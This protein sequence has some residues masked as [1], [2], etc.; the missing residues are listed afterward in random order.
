MPEQF[1]DATT[2]KV[3]DDDFAA[4]ITTLQTRVAADDVRR[5]SLPQAPE[6]YKGE[7]PADFKMPD[8]IT[9]KL[10]ETNPAYVEAR[11]MAH[12]MGLDQAQF[13]K[14]LSA[15]AG[16]L[17]QEQVT[18]KAARDAEIAKLGAA[19]PARVDAVT[20][21]LTAMDGSAD[22]GDAKALASMMW[23]ERSVVAFENLIKKFTNQGGARFNN[24]HRDGEQNLPGRKSAEEVAKMSPAQRLDYNRQFDQSQMPAWRDPR[25]A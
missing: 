11:K 10:D 21:W 9:F 3:K 5:N 12:E 22:K 4:H 13:S 2:N 1:W 16:A 24:S 14:L 15:H 18:F 8:G 17:A 20:Q 25:A 7:L 19:G 23:T 6:A